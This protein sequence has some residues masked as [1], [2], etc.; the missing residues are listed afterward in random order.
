MCTVAPDTIP[1]DILIFVILITLVSIGKEYFIIFHVINASVENN[2]KL[3]S[4]ATKPTLLPDI[5]PVSSTVD[6]LDIFESIELNDDS[7]QFPPPSCEYNKTCL[8][9][10]TVPFI[11]LTGLP[12]ANPLFLLVLEKTVFFISYFVFATITISL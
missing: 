4:P 2:N 1:D 11:V 6:L 7:F 8:Y 9:E 5:Q 3:F 10:Y 12:N